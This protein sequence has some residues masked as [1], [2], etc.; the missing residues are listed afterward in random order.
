MQS[1]VERDRAAPVTVSTSRITT[2]SSACGNSTPD[3]GDPGKKD[4]GP[5]SN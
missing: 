5:P 1:T 4:A 3:A 2:C